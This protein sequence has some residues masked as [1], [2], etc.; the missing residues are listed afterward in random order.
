MHFTCS[1]LFGKSVLLLRVF[2]KPFPILQ[3]LL[4]N[5][6]PYHG[7]RRQKR[8]SGGDGGVRNVLQF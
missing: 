4:A 2:S 7:S 8:K 5:I 6:W 3:V 1:H